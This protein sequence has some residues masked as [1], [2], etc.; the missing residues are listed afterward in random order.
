MYHGFPVIDFHTHI[1]PD[2]LATRAIDAILQGREFHKF[3]DATLSGL[4][5]NM[6]EQGIEASVIQPIITKPSQLETT[7]RW[8]ASVAGER[9]IPFGGV[10]PLSET[11]ESDIDFVRSLGIRGLKFHAEYQNYIVDTPEVMPLYRYAAHVGLPA[12]FHGGEDL[13]MKPPFKSSPQQ[14]AHIADEIPSL[15]MVVAHLGGFR[16]WDDVEEYLVGRDN[17]W[18]DTSMGFE[19]F[20]HEQFLRIVKKHGAD[21]ILFG[22]DSP[23]SDASAELQ[24]LERLL[25]NDTDFEKIVCLNAKRL[26]EEK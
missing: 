11:F 6:D 19:Y 14:Y 9:I 15:R 12:L 25:K 8:A 24:T 7:N 10:Y 4:L 1:F 23:W 20:P 5:K 2:K 3:S 22:S 21:R 17:V 13:S 16:Q 26:L 18:L